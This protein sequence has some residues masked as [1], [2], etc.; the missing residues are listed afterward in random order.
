[1][2]EP[3]LQISILPHALIYPKGSNP[4]RVRSVSVNPAILEYWS[5]GVMMKGLMPIFN[6]PILHRSNTPRP[7]LSGTYGCLIFIKD[8]KIWSEVY[9]F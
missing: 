2:L 6:T 1:M 5:V 4:S 7:S 8:P 3:K 9:H